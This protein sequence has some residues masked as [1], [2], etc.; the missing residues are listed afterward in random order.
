M[1]TERQIQLDRVR[2]TQ[3]GRVYRY[4]LHDTGETLEV[5]AYTES[6]A[7][8]VLAEEHPGVDAS[9]LGSRDLTPAD[10]P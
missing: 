2:A 3:R 10:T 6:R 7:Y 9:Y 4:R 5:V 1:Q 8:R